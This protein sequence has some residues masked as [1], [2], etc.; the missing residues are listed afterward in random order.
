[1]TDPH[2]RDRGLL[3]DRDV[4]GVGVLPLLHSPLRFEG[5]PREAP[6]DA[7]DLG[8]HNEEIYASLLGLGSDEIRVLR[9]EG[10]I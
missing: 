7:P 5:E 4:P 6:Q 1:V 8:E 10:V 9:A 3:F 2:L